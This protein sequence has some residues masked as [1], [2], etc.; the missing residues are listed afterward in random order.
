[1]GLSLH[2]P[3]GAADHTQGGDQGWKAL[4]RVLLASPPTATSTPLTSARTLASRPPRPEA[5]SL[6]MPP[7]SLAYRFSLK[8][9]LP[10]H[11]SWVAKPTGYWPGQA[12]AVGCPQ[13][14]DRGDHL[15]F[16]VSP[17]TCQSSLEESLLLSHPR[18]AP[19]LRV[20]TL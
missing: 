7:L 12:H 19:C 4:H 17:A 10:E 14:R 3:Q 18:V 16:L 20:T 13:P 9:A 2:Q 1:M 5:T 11:G 6:F 8:G 15:A